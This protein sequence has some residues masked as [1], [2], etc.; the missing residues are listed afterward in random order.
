MYLTRLWV[1]PRSRAARRDLADCYQLHR[2]VMAA[3]PDASGDA[4][5][6]SLGVLYRVEDGGDRITLYVQSD[7]APN[8]DH[9]PSGYLV[10]EWFGDGNPATRPLDDAWGGL[11]DGTTL[12]F[13]LLANPTR[14]VDTR[15]DAN[16][17]RRNG[18]RVP[19]GS[20]A[21]RLAWLARHGGA[22]GFALAMTSADASVPDVSTSVGQPTS[23]K[24]A[25]ASGKAERRVTFVP[26]LFDGRLRVED[27]EAFRDTLRRGIGPGKAFGFGLLSVAAT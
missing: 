27:A 8:W 23:G 19:L 12:R 26:V 6:A 10:E 15:S 16:G 7:V 4:A 20:D 5:R 9:L 14:K 11:T 2:T 18:R 21:D 24:S 17:G 25:A 1:D 13:R 3:F 22:G